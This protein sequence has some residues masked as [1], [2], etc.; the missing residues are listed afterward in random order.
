VVPVRVVWQEGTDV[1]VPPVLDVVAVP[2]LVWEDCGG[3]FGGLE[4]QMFCPVGVLLGLGPPEWP[5]L[6]GFW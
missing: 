6:A 1:V 5:Q 3:K 2:G 4:W